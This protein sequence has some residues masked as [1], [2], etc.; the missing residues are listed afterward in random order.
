[1]YLTAVVP[2]GHCILR[3]ERSLFS[4]H[5]SDAGYAPNP[6]FLPNQELF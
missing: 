1:M 5:V 6:F 4:F 2:V 3:S